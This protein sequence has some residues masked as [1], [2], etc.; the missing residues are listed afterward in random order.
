MLFNIGYRYGMEQFFVIYLFIAQ[1]NVAGNG[2][3]EYKAILH[4][5]AALLPPHRSRNVLQWDTAQRY[6]AGLGLIKFQQQFH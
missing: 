6:V 1:R 5:R 2:I 4:Y 3:G